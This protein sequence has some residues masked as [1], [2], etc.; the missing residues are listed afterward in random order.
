MLNAGKQLNKTVV[1]DFPIPT[2]SHCIVY[3]T[4]GIIINIK[5]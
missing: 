1:L 2:Q 4:V 5:K 3:L